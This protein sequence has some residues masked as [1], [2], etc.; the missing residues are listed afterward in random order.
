MLIILKINRF[1][2]LRP[3]DQFVKQRIDKMVEIRKW[4]QH[5]QPFSVVP[6]PHLKCHA[7]LVPLPKH[8]T[9]YEEISS[10]MKKN[11]KIQQI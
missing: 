10:Q 5:G 2:I 1:Q 11:R 7:V 4:T 8:S 6:N 9:L 3:I